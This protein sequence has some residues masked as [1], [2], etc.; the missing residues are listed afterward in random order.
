MTCVEDLTCGVWNSSGFQPLEVFRFY[1]YQ[2][3]IP[4]AV[5]LGLFLGIL[6]AGIYLWSRSLNILVIL[7]V[8]ATTVT[9]VFAASTVT[10]PHL[11][12]IMWII[13]LAIAS[14]VTIMLL[15]VLRE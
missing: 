2:Y 13:G 4:D 8:Y 12:S 5:V 3:G 15:K 7:G 10:E 6:I 11:H 14:I 9:T 1:Y